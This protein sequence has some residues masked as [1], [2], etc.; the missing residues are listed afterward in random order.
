MAANFSKEEREER[1]ILVG[2][3]FLSHPDCSTRDI[4]DYFSNIENGF[5]ISNVTVLDYIRKYKEMLNSVQL[6]EIDEHIDSNK[7]KGVSC[8]YVRY[9]V[10]LFAQRV[11]E[12]LGIDEIA[13]DY[14]VSYWTVYRDLSERLAK[15]DQ[16]L[17]FKVCDEFD[18][19]RLNNL[20]KKK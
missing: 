13:C 19:R 11:L 3:Y 12:G 18:K 7:P 14:N 17:Y 5:K 1:M 6:S 10:L 16:E 20:Q 9:R 4:A 2:E 15:I 8:A